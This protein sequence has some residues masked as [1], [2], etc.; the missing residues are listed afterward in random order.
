MFSLL[1]GF[2]EY[3]FRKAEYRILIL[4]VDKAGKT[5]LLEKVKSLFSN[6]EGLPPNQILPTVGLNIGR[7]EACGTKLVF[8]DLGGQAALRSIWEKY[9][10]EAHAVLFCVD[11]A[12][13]ERLE[14]A[15]N[16]L[17]RALLNKELDGAPLLIL[18]NKRDLSGRDGVANVQSAFGKLAAD[19]PDRP[20]RVMLAC[21]LTGDGLR[22]SVQWL[23][24]MT[25]KAR[26]TRTLAELATS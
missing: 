10:A 20:A 24:D 3:L 12:A 25:R 1:Y 5:T 9:Y 19:R 14:D 17:E 6:V 18:A 8:W 15:R 22:E 11:A 23:V 13:P 7:I 21:A 16:A 4:G 26:R 2:Y